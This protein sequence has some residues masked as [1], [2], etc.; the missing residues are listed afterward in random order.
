MQQKLNKKIKC[1][2]FKSSTTC[3]PWKDSYFVIIVT[4]YDA[5]VVENLAYIFNYTIGK[6]GYIR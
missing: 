5:K 1:Y 4:D 3:A 2:L 6:D